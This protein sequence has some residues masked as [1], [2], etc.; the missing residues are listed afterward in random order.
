[1]P[2]LLVLLTSTFGVQAYAVEGPGQRSAREVL[3]RFS[4]ATGAEFDVGNRNPPDRESTDAPPVSPFVA[5]GAS[6]AELQLD[7]SWLDWCSRAAAAIAVASKSGSQKIRPPGMRAAGSGGTV[8]ITTGPDSGFAFDLPPGDW[9]LGRSAAADLPLAD[10]YVSRHPLVMSNSPGGL[11]ACWGPGKTVTIPV[12]GHTPSTMT[13]GSTRLSIIPVDAPTIIGAREFEWP[14]PPT[15][16][17]PRPPSW[18]YYVLP[19]VFG[20]VLVLLTGMWWFLLFT[21][22]GPLSAG[23]NWLLEKRRFAEE[24]RTSYRAYRS[25]LRDFRAEVDRSAS[26]CLD[27]ARALPLTS[28]ALVLGCGTAVAPISVHGRP[29]VQQPDLGRVSAR[30]RLQAADIDRLIERHHIAGDAFEDRIHP[31]LPD[32]PILFN[33]HEVDLDVSGPAPVVADVVRSVIASASAVGMPV[34]YEEEPSAIHH[35]ELLA[36]DIRVRAVAAPTASAVSRSQGPSTLRIAVTEHGGL[37]RAEI[38]SPDDV[39]AHSSRQRWRIECT[40]DS[41]VGHLTVLDPVRPA[42]VPL[43]VSGPIELRRLRSQRFLD[44]NQRWRGPSNEDLPPRSLS[45]LLGARLPGDSEQH[46]TDRGT[47]GAPLGTGPA[48][49]LLIDLVRDGP[50]ALVAGT[51]GSGKSVLLQTWVASLAAAMSP[52]DLRFV[53]IDFKGGAAFTPF[54][55]LVHVDSIVSNLEPSAAMRAL[56]S[57]QAEILRRE[58]LFADAGTASIEEFNS[59]HSPPL[60]RVVVIIDEF[61]ALIQDNPSGTETVESL[62]ALGRSLGIHLILATQRPA[63]IVTSRMKANINLRIALRVRDAPDSWEVIESDAAAAL[64]PAAP[65]MAYVSRGASPV[66][67]RV[68]VPDFADP[69]TDG[70]LDQVSWTRLHDG[71]RGTAVLRQHSEPAG[72][73]RLTVPELVR[74]SQAWKADSPDHATSR[75]VL[76]PLPDRLSQTQPGALGLLDFPDEN[77][78]QLWLYDPHRDGSVI[79]TGGRGRGTSTAV[80]SLASAVLEAGHLVAH[81]GVERLRSAHPNLVSSAHSDLWAIEYLLGTL[82]NQPSS[83]PPITVCIDDYEVLRNSFEGSRRLI[84]LEKLLTGGHGH[85]QLQFVVAAERRVLHSPI[86]PHARTRIVFPPSDAHECVHF[87]MSARRFE[88]DWPS[89]RAV[90]VGPVTAST[91]SEGA[92]V[93]L[94]HLPGETEGEDGNRVAPMSFRPAAHPRDSPW[95]VRNRSDSDANHTAATGHGEEVVLGFGPLGE[96]VTWHPNRDGPVLSIRGSESTVRRTLGK[97]ADSRTRGGGQDPSQALTVIPEAHLADPDHLDRAMHGR[98]CILGYPLHHTPGY[99]SP[100]HR[101][102]SLGPTLVIGARTEGELADIGLRDLPVVPGPLTRGWFVTS[103]RAIPVDVGDL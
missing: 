56:R 65:G 24:S 97:L 90:A 9:T 42:R 22:S 103:Q 101:A 35:P 4:D 39:S 72:L 37:T 91:G 60:P 8:E 81:M 7:D 69:A 30:A 18:V 12:D 99:S 96:P 31:Y 27:R 15:V 62:T 49:P 1:M 84:R 10:P 43:P 29:A 68:A 87:G 11:T 79:L 93:Q 44:L 20:V 71:T 32:C 5:V 67:F 52:A 78:N 89:G 19:L 57:L 102:P 77:R 66:L 34:Q 21:L 73:P 92:D 63:G 14:I 25:T 16:E 46:G 80:R 75:V 41:S 17:P 51:T 28:E 61:Q 64:D 36:A 58:E 47:A 53:L 48:G 59:S 3:D 50:H 82:E 98:A 54:A 88:G 86:G 26:E 94:V 85:R 55:E 23:L 83:G 45:D 76:P 74:R 33:P 95:P 38:R 2:S 40:A 100:L 70:R 13:I 6:A